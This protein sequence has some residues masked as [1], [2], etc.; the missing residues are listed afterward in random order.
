M[1]LT[2]HERQGND[3]VA[4]CFASSW[5]EDY[6][7]YLA[8]NYP[9]PHR[10]DTRVADTASRENLRNV[11]P[12]MANGEMYCRFDR[13]ITPTVTDGGKV[14]ALNNECHDS[15][16]IHVVDNR[17]R[18]YT[19]R[20]R[21]DFTEMWITFIRLAYFYDLHLLLIPTLARVWEHGCGQNV[22]PRDQQNSDWV[23]TRFQ[24][25][26]MGIKWPDQCD[27]DQLCDLTATGDDARNTD[28]GRA[29]RLDHT[30]E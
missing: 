16:Q 20:I 15:V 22:L 3:S 2:A 10:N 12:I 23:P 8:Y 27:I 5:A 14:F 18:A 26:A 21:L 19:N 4:V 30:Q 6:G 11:T 1:L 25:I 24:L 9:P 7:V 28:H 13:K 29:C 17:Q